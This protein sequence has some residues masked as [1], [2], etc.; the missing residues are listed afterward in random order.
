MKRFLLIAAF[1]LCWTQVSAQ[2]LYVPSA[3]YSTIQSTINDANDDDT[4]VVSAGTYQENINF[5]GKAI[6]VRSVDPNDPNMV[7]ATII[8]GSNPVDPNIGSVVTFNGGEDANSVLSGFTITGGSGSW[9]PIAWQFYQVYWNRCGGGALCYNMAAPTISKNVFTSN[10]AGQGGGIYLYGDPV[11]PNNPSNPPV[12]ISPVIIDNIFINNSAVVAHGF[13][14][15][16]NNYPV[17]DHGDGGAIVSFQGVDAIIRG[18]LIE[19]NHADSYGGGLH[20]RQ[21]SN[22]LIED[23]NIIGNDSIL[24]AGIHVTYTSAPNIVDNLIQAN[25]TGTLYDLGG[26]GIYVYYYSN[27]LIERNT[28]TQ[29]QSSNGAGILVAWTSNPT[30]RNNMIVKNVKSAGIRVKGDSIPIITNNTIVGNTASKVY[31]G[32]VDCMTDSV[33]IIENNIIASN[34]NSF[35]IYAW[36][37][38]PT[39]RYNDVWDNGAGNYSSVISDQTGI[40]GNISIAPNFIDPGSNNYALNYDSK[41]INA[42]DPNFVPAPN[43]TDYDGDRRLLGQYV[44][45][46]ADEVWPVW[47]ITSNNQYET[48]QQAINDA[49][50]YDTIIVAIGTHTGT[51]NKDIDF[52]GKAVTLRSIDPN[53]PDIIASTIIDCQASGR[54]FR[55]HSGEDTNSIVN[56]FTITNGGNIYDGGAIHC[57]GSSPAIT[58]CIIRDNIINGHGAGIYCGSDSYGNPSNTVITN[59]FINSNTFIPSGY[60]GGI[61]CYKSSPIITNCIITNNSATGSGR[62][63]GGICCWGDEEAGGNA[64]VANC[65]VSDNSA[66]HRGGGLYAY[67]SSPTF[68]N[69][70]VIGNRALEGGGIGSFRE[71]N[72]AVINCIVRNNIAPDG[73]QLALINTRRVWPVSIGTEMTVSFSDIEGGF[74][75]ACIDAG[76]TLHWGNGNIDLDPNFVDPGYWDDANTPA[77]PNDDFFITGNY[78]LLPISGCIDVGDNSS[79]PSVST[80]DIDGEQRI[81]NNIVDM[82]ADEVVTNPADFNTDG[83]VDYFD[84]KVMTDEWLGSGSELQSDLFDDD[85]IDFVDY[86]VF[87]EQWL[88]TAAWH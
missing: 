22:G 31:G 87:A 88:W 14:P 25:A 75:Q 60:G 79:V 68:V 78:H 63:G 61:Y 26:G 70:T 4:I 10:T 83:I 64:L 72:P 34:G 80:T 86:A 8:D 82:G 67:W 48:I 1:T 18:N 57:S 6:T 16:N 53:S 69:C 45:I 17:N 27:P 51:G 15:P 73:N 3:E 56:G 50:D 37:T 20:L 38:P 49:N 47:N 71:S 23:N 41:C 76:C 54:G 46:G 66:G 55:F 7:A 21:W 62:H 29:N 52:G 30:I 35:G 85:F 44:D 28:I 5:L 43:E 2:T 58:N 9:L 77:D 24:G 74:G 36:P 81:F 42:G 19:N 13:N 33:P 65:I 11:N 39:I 84:L 32:G 12:H 40:N 59:C